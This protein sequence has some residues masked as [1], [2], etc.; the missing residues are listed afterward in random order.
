M[1]SVHVLNPG[2][3]AVGATATETRRVGGFEHRLTYVI[4]ERTP[5]SSFAFQGVDGPVRPFGRR[6]VEPLDGGSRSRVTIEL[7]FRGNRLGKL[8]IP[9]VRRWARKHVPESQRRLKERLES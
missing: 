2:P 5:P 1:S 4:I 8:L 7:D 3:T 9:A 6:T